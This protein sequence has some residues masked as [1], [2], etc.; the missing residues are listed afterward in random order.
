MSLEVL[1]ENNPIIRK[2]CED[3]INAV[4]DDFNQLSGKS[5]Y[6][7]GGAGFLG[8]YLCLAPAYW[9]QYKKRP[10][11]ENIQIIISDIFLL[12]RPKWVEALSEE[13]YMQVLTH[14][15]TEGMPQ[16]ISPNYIFHAASIASPTF[17]R[18]HP[19]ETIEANIFGLKHILEYSRKN[20]LE[21]LIFFSS[22]EI[23]GDPPADQI[24]TKEDF[25]G[26]VSCTGPR[27]CYDE[28][29]RLGET[30]CVSYASQHSVPVTVV[31]P[32]NNYGPG[33][34]LE[35]ARVLPDFINNILGNSD[36]RIFSD[37]SPR[38]TYCYISDAIS[39]YYKALLIG[40]RGEAY[41]IGIQQPEISVLEL[42]ELTKE[43][44]TNM[45]DYQGKIIC[46]NKHSDE[47]YLTD[48][49]QRRCPNIEKARMQLD[50]NPHVD[51]EE[52]INNY[53]KWGQAIKVN[54]L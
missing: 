15:C 21:G 10:N 9:N 39:G 49:P 1:L 2:D 12:R 19:I 28:S 16:G 11:Q 27:A 50:Y 18:K 38:R 32:F 46:N 41:N 23:Y 31:R 37:G 53:L 14:N 8:Y 35:D 34:A 42:A 7:T 26:F 43:V 6:I 20:S 24:P 13:S 44:A 45:F 51:V 36:I 33:L 17:Y 3:I 47:K 30:L 22:S 5:I 52:G 29:K 48:N 25:R 54:G 40:Q 4:G